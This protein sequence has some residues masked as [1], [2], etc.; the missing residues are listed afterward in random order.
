M[1]TMRLTLSVASLSIFATLVAAPAMSRDWQVQTAS[2]QKVAAHFYC[3]GL[4][5]KTCAENGLPQIEVTGPPSDGT[6]SFSNILSSN[7][8]TRVGEVRVG[9][10]CPTVPR[11]CIQIYYTPSPGYAGSDHFS[12]SVSNPDGQIWHDTMTVIVH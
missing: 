12:Y 8:F 2:G 11:H 10:Q 9:K 4:K 7:T 6:V 3:S 5:Q 1:R